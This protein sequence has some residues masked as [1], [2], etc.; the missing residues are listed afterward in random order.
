MDADLSAL[1]QTVGPF[2]L[3]VLAA[4]ETAFVTGLVVPA[5]VAT[6]L[7]AFL[8]TEG[9][10]MLGDVALGAGLGA[11]AGDSLGFWLGRRYGGALLSGEGR[12]RSLARR[13]EPRAA[14]LFRRHPLY[15]VS[16]ARVASF[17]RTL[18][19][20]LA[21]MSRVPYG[22]FLAYDMIGVAAWAGLYLGAGV[23]AGR[24]WRWVSGVLG[25]GWAIVFAVVGLGLWFAARRRALR[26]P[27]EAGLFPAPAG[28]EG[29][30]APGRPTPF[31]DPEAR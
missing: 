16:L 27:G 23:L 10:L 3:F 7:G 6:A 9:R 8:A 13:Q 14:A 4:A 19:P 12:L 2:V 31:R 29:G 20:M 24:S 22:R 26:S 21:G 25:T 5:G 30:G 1:L 28:D 18:M 17:V 15:A 11:L